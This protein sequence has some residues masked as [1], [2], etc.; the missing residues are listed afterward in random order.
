LGKRSP[1]GRLQAGVVPRQP[2]GP[3]LA[4]RARRRA[5]HRILTR[6]TSISLRSHAGSGN[7]AGRSAGS[8][9]SV[10]YKFVVRHAALADALRPGYRQGPRICGRCKC[11]LDFYGARVHALAMES[12]TQRFGKPSRFATLV[13]SGRRRERLA[14]GVWSDCRTLSRSQ[15]TFALWAFLLGTS[16]KPTPRKANEALKPSVTID[17]VVLRPFLVPSCICFLV[18]VGV[19]SRV[20]KFGE[21]GSK[22]CC[23]FHRCRQHM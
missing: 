1:L 8:K 6:Y 14:I 15:S 19:E 11:G 16:R 13:A 22:G 7:V 21:V 12:R 17:H 23:S 20:E 2:T 18:T 4:P 9:H 5:F 10:G 3:W